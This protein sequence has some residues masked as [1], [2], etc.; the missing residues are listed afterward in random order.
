MN[1]LISIVIPVYNNEDSLPILFDDLKKL[2][3]NL[4]N[5]NY[6]L[7]LVFVD[8]GSHDNSLEVL[9]SLKSMFSNIKIIELTKNFGA[10]NAS[11][12]GLEN[13]S[14]DYF[15]ILAADLQDPPELILTM[16][17]EIS[18][19]FKFIICER[20]SRVDPL[21]KKFF[22]KL[23]YRIFRFLA[24]SDYPKGGFDVF[25][26]HK[27]LLEQH[28]KC[29]NFFTTSLFL[30]SLGYPYKSLKVHRPARIHGKSSYTFK[31]SL[32]LAIDNIFST[33]VMPLRIMTIIGFTVSI[34]SIIY[35]LIILVSA[36]LNNITVPGYASTIIL[37]SILGGI[38]ILMLGI[39]GEYI[40]RIYDE[41]TRKPKSVI[42]K[43]Y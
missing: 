40:W 20:E 15:S 6:N 43:I 39:V 21:T 24:V 32:S 23:Y 3:E 17:K 42:E 31:K 10:K 7:E 26:A 18:D 8:D 16:L 4:G 9:L 1:K 19:E 34:L 11:R 35:A 27:T 38:I 30:F 41:I 2:E 25:L 12:A 33:S 28:L 22:A 14:G 37:I 29:S 36:I 5:K 13:I